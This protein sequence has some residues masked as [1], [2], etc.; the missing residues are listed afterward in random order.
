MLLLLI[1]HTYSVSNTLI[2]Y[3]IDFFRRWNDCQN[4]QK[5]LMAQYSLH[6]RLFKNLCVYAFHLTFLM[7]NLSW[8]I[9]QKLHVIKRS[10]L[11]SD[12]TQGSRCCSHVIQKSGVASNPSSAFLHNCVVLLF[13]VAYG[14][15]YLL[16]FTIHAIPNSSSWFT[17]LYRDMVFFKTK[18]SLCRSTSANPKRKRSRIS[19]QYVTI[20]SLW[21]TWTLSI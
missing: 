14:T 11:L 17:F 19:E 21:C 12:C 18:W 13:F 9:L 5:I 1:Q 20:P 8:T 6:S 15:K 2:Y 4:H 7:S 10:L 3:S 16:I